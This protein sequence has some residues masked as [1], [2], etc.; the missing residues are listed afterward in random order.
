MFPPPLRP[1]PARIRALYSE[2]L[3]KDAVIKIFRQ[4]L[5]QDQGRKEGQGP[6]HNLPKGAGVGAPLRP[7]SSTPAISVTT[8]TS[9][10]RGKG[11][12]VYL[13][14]FFVL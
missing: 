7:A 6:R 12:S 14:F 11:P 4:R 1:C 13:S 9:N 3:E 5:H 2:I 10:S 8:C